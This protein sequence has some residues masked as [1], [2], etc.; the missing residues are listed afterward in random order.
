MGRIP[1]L[2]DADY[3]TLFRS[4]GLCEDVWW[5]RALS[6]AEEREKACLSP[7]EM[8]NKQRWQYRDKLFGNSLWW[9]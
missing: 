4:E 8:G 2:R 9:R 7:E 6:E 3:H 5:K 1:L